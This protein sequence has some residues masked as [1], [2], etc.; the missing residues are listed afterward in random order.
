MTTD[1]T[2]SGTMCT[3][4]GSS[5]CVESVIE[6]TILHACF[7]IFALRGIFGNLY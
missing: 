4:I 3:D 7:L 2:H 1:D 5:I 6:G